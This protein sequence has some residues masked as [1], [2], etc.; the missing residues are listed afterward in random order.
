[1]LQRL[2]LLESHVTTTPPLAVNPLEKYRKMSN[3]DLD[4]LD[5]MYFIGGKD[6]TN[7]LNDIIKTDKLFLQ[8][9]QE[10]FTR[11]EER[12]SAVKKVRVIFEKL[13]PHFRH[14]M[15]EYIKRFEDPVQFNS[16]GI[17]V[18]MYNQGL[19]TKYTVNLVLFYITVKNLGTAQHEKWKE[20]I[21]WGQEV[22]CFALTE[23]SHGSNVRGIQTTATYDQATEEFI[24]NTPDDTAMKFWIGGAAKSATVS[25]VFANLI[26]NGKN[27]GPHVFIVPLRNK[28][29]YDVLPGI[30]IGDCGKKLGQESIDNG[31]ILFNNFRIPREN[32]LNK[33][34]NV[35]KEGK[36][37]TTIPSPDQRLALILGGISQG[38][39]LIIG[40]SPRIIGYGLK[41]ALR[42]AAMR[43]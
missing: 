43:R 32:M 8:E 4:L 19:S 14:D 25:V 28:K 42:F 5:R 27:E 6:I 26:L 34:S 10:E 18:Y 2:N 16:I 29:T 22:G 11:E 37:E 40:F 7:I 1:M 24:I 15:E 12:E 3:L 33:M 23:L 9:T 13:L 17:P 36:F 41:I 31:F 21:K 20:A 39:L 38:R 30:I 35:T